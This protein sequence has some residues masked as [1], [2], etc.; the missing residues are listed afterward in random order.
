MVAESSGKMATRSKGPQRAG[1]SGQTRLPHRV[2]RRNFVREEL[3]RASK[4]R[5]KNR[6]QLHREGNHG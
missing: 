4:R 2:S 6:R 5:K 1:N 3:A